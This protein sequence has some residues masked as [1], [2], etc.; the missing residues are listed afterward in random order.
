[1]EM[2]AEEVTSSLEEGRPSDLAD[3]PLRLGV[4]QTVFE[5]ILAWMTSGDFLLR[6]RSAGGLEIVPVELR[7]RIA[8]EAEGAGTGPNARRGAAP[9]RR[10]ELGA[11]WCCA[12]KEA[13]GRDRPGEGVGAGRRR[14]SRDDGTQPDPGGRT[15]RPATIRYWLR[16]MKVQARQIS[17][18]I[19]AVFDDAPAVRLCAVQMLGAFDDPDVRWQLYRVAVEDPEGSI[20]TAAVTALGQHASG[21]IVAADIAG[22]PGNGEPLSIERCGCVAAI[23]GCAGY[24]AV[25]GPG[26]AAGSST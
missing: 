19:E 22:G 17:A 2:I 10:S 3:L 5:E 15:A 23:P 25:A 20:R 16:R 8:E 4:A 7:G 26:C 14:R 11:A 21:G 24:G 1:M 9:G 18:L 6:E 12:A 13:A